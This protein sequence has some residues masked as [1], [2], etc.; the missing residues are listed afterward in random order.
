VRQAGYEPF[1]A[2]DEA[3]MTQAMVRAPVLCL[4]DLEA[5][6]FKWERLTRFVKGPGKKNNHVP[7]LGFGS[8]V[9]AELKAQALAAGCTAIVEPAMLINDLPGIID[10]NIWRVNPDDCARPLPP[11]VRAGIEQFNQGLYFE[12]HETLEDAW[13]EEAGLIR[14]LYQ[15]ILQVAVGYLHINRHNWR[16][17]VKVL[18]RG[19]PKAAHFRPVCH[20]I[21]VEDVVLQA[22]RVR[23]ELERLGPDGIAEFDKTTFP[24]IR[25]DGKIL[26]GSVPD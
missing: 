26:G 24:K 15:G 7:V 8:N 16:G 18:E 5:T 14:L 2:A 10:R 22:Q 4:V 11:L 6:S 13:N 19:I 9:D 3:V 17:A 23:A 21:D 12:C 25:V 1:F 20:G